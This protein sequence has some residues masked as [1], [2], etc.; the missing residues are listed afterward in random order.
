MPFKMHKKKKIPEKKYVCLPYL[1]FSDSLPQNTHIF[2]CGL[3]GDQIRD[4]ICLKCVKLI[5]SDRIC[6]RGKTDFN[7]SLFLFK[8]FIV[9]LIRRFY[10]D[11]SNKYQQKLKKKDEKKQCE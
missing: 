11:A 5:A 1:K 2:L 3:S 6:M 10:R 8:M 9:A 7:I 4:Y